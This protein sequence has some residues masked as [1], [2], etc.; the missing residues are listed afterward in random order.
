MVERLLRKR[1][2]KNL[3]RIEGDQELNN[4]GEMN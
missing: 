3:E 1:V 4:Y 2:L